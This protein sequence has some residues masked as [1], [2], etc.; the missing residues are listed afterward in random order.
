M[1]LQE[2][3]MEDFSTLVQWWKALVENE[4]QSNQRRRLQVRKKRKNIGENCYGERG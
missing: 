3:P 1:T 4:L 2:I